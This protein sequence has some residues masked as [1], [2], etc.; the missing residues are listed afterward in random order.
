MSI[1]S[2]AADLDSVLQHAGVAVTIGAVSSYGILKREASEVASDS[3][4]IAVKGR[5]YTLRVREGTFSGLAQDA[6]V[7]AD[8]SS[9][10]IRDI[11]TAMP[12]GSRTLILVEATP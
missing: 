2:L 4:G 7:T 6:S 3:G 12:D 11:G 8:G 5:R 9:Y 10:K 1:A